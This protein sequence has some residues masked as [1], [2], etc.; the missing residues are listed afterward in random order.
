M[1]N[2]NYSREKVF[3]VALVVGL[4]LGLVACGNKSAGNNTSQS[5]IV[6]SELNGTESSQKESLHTEET[7][8][9]A[10]ENTE[11]G[12]TESEAAT[13]DDSSNSIPHKHE[14]VSEVTQAATCTAEGARTF[15][16]SCGDSYEEIIAT[17]HVMEYV[18]NDDET[19]FVN[20]TETATCPYCGQTDT[21]LKYGTM[22]SERAF[23]SYRNSCV[24]VPVE[25]FE[26][27]D[28]FHQNVNFDTWDCQ[29]VDHEMG[30][31]TTR[32]V[33]NDEGEKAL[34][35]GF[36][37]TWTSAYEDTVFENGKTGAEA[38]WSYVGVSLLPG[39]YSDW[40]EFYYFEDIPGVRF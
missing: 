9:L 28:F 35:T 18:Y 24:E 25:Q 29:Y 23:T 2:K 20:G 12:A 40:L 39:S 36:Y 16:C 6:N 8:S 27:E 38:R 26:R 34:L 13:T 7:E 33:Y 4:S 10:S 30:V 11:S 1:C 3:V 31:F 15:K 37:G 32:W 14:Y 5:E 19:I 17:V 21:R 22:G